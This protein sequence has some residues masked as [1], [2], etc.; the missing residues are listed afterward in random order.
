M[1]QPGSAKAQEMMRIT[2]AYKTYHDAKTNS[3][4]SHCTPPS[5]SSFST[6][7]VCQYE[8]EHLEWWAKQSISSYYCQRH[9]AIYARQR[10]SDSARL[11]LSSSPQVKSSR[12]YTIWAITLTPSRSA[13][14]LRN[15][16]SLETET[17]AASPKRHC[18]CKPR[19]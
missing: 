15:V 3:K 8:R 7:H 14:M 10:T 12:L 6:Q 11:Y 17:Q 5:R 4:S 13:H 18:N 16:L 9:F 2:V 1:V 19:Q